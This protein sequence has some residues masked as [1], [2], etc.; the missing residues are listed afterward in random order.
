MSV[1]FPFKI[2]SGVARNSNIG[3]QLKMGSLRISLSHCIGEAFW[4]V[5]HLF[6]KKTLAIK[7]PCLLLVGSNIE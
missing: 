6:K 5:V 7:G 1:L 4:E 2:M 3:D